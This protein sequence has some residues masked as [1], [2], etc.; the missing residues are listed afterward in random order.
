MKNP[1]FSTPIRVVGGLLIDSGR[2]T[3]NNEGDDFL[4]NKKLSRLA[5]SPKDT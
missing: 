4:A 5:A 1:S 3:Y 2:S